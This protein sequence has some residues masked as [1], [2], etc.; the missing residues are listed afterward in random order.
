[1]EKITSKPT[2]KVIGTQVPDS[3]YPIKIEIG[4]KIEVR[5][6]SAFAKAWIEPNDVFRAYLME[7]LRAS[8]ANDLLDKLKGSDISVVVE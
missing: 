2:L 3:G 7:R 1:M 6:R 8:D 4:Q 5:G